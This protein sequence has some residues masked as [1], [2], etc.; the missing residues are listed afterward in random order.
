MEHLSGFT[1]RRHCSNADHFHCVALRGTILVGVLRLRLGA[2]C[3][4]D[5]QR[6]LH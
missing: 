3:I 1:S 4:P 2:A 6:L 5:A